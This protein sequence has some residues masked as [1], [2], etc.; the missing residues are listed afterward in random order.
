MVLEW[1]RGDQGRNREE[2][3][4]TRAR[5]RRWRGCWRGGGRDPLATRRQDAD[6]E[7]RAAGTD[8]NRVDDTQASLK[9]LCVGVVRVFITRVADA[10]EV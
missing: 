5:E 9:A 1:R 7:W 8:L 4:L 6:V 10:I 2:S 3:D